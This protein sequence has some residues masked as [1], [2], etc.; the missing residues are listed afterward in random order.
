MIREI[1]FIWCVFL[2]SQ[3]V[4]TLWMTLIIFL[5]KLIEF[6]IETVRI[7]NIIK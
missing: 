7:I 6:D 3:T 1:Y 4:F 2:V 5:K